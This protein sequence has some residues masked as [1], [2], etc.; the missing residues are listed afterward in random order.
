MLQNKLTEGMEIEYSDLSKIKG[1]L[2]SKICQ[3]LAINRE[4][5]KSL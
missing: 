5:R 1:Q 3:F 2:N 4:Q